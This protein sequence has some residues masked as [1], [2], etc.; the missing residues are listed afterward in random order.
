MRGEDEMK[1]V[2]LGGRQLL[3]A[4]VDSRYFA[5]A[6]EYPHEAADLQMGA[7]DGDKVRCANRAN[8][9]YCFDLN[10]GEC[11]LP[12]GGPQLTSFQ[13]KSAGKISAYAWSGGTIFAGP[14]KPLPT[15]IRFSSYLPEPTKSCW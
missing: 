3:L 14:N 11:E 13:L 1:P 15:Q 12:K 5:F 10:T 7:L 8:H 2:E 4:R 9:G 6:G